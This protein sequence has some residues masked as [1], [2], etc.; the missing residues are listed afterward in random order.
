MS[1][2]SDREMRTFHARQAARNKHAVPVDSNIV[3]KKFKPALPDED[4]T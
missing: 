2:K 1:K 4:P 3:N